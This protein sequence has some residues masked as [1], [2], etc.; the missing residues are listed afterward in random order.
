MATVLGELRPVTEGETTYLTKERILIGAHRLCDIIIRSPRAMRTALRT[1]PAA[2]P[3]DRP[4]RR[5]DALELGVDP[6]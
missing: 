1:F 4:Q 2:R 5:P 3:V 6:V